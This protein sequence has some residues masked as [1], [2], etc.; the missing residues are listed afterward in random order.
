MLVCQNFALNYR[1][2]YC[3]RKQ[4]IVV[5]V[6]EFSDWEQ[7]LADHS[8]PIYNVGIVA[9]LLGVDAQVVRRYDQDGLVQP[10][11]SDA[12]QR[13][14]SRDDIAR[15]ARA[16]DLAEEGIS[17]VGVARIL[18]L[19]D[20]VARLNAEVEAEQADQSEAD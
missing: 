13:R 3:Q 18:A 11:R 19:Q 8:A 4:D 7:R 14:Y 2:E 5:A 1:Q 9:E 15:L 10:G 6:S 17:M 12:G 20:E 16:L